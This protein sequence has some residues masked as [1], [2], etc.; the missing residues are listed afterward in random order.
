MA[1][2]E[3]IKKH[4]KTIWTIVFLFLLAGFIFLFQFSNNKSANTLQK[5]TEVDRNKK[6]E[7]NEE[8]SFAIL[9]DTQLFDLPESKGGFVKAVRNIANYN[10]SFVM[11]VG[12]LI[13]GCETSETCENKYEK[14]KRIAKIIP[15]RIYP[16]MGN[17]DRVDKKIADEIW[18]KSFK[19]PDNGPRGYEE[20]VYSFDFKN[21][22]FI[23]LNSEK[24]RLHRV[25]II[26][27][28]WLENNLRENKL[29]NVF[30]FFHEPALPSSYKINQSLDIY[31]KDR[32]ALWK[33]I[34]KYNVTAVFNGHEHI[35]SRRLITSSL[36]PEATN[37]IYQFI[38]GNT[39]AYERL[40]PK[41]SESVDFNYKDQNF[42]IVNI[43]G[44]KIAVNL[45]SIN[46]A[47][48]DKFQF[49]K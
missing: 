10:T 21:S 46:G 8:F 18:Q 49:S 26:Q 4:A 27:R 2:L 6:E 48:V 17:H 11:T 37:N 39:D 29:E 43:E 44:K 36:F 15:V 32:D 13:Q 24:P 35:Y 7:K 16:V 3:K 40:A 12:D 20:L 34:D 33:I 22:H 30:I 5:Q 25:D 31:K 9:G 23:I 14:W 42:V 41:Q 1:F 45:Y 19:L 47:L 28:E 38:V